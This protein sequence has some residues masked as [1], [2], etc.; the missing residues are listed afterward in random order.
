MN[1]S[2]GIDDLWIIAIAIMVCSACALL[3]V[4]LVLRKLSMIGDAI[5]H[6]VLFG[7]VVAFLLTSSRGSAVILIGATAVGILTTLLINFLSKQ[8]KVQEDA[9]IGVVFTWLFALGVILISYYAGQ[10]DLDQDCVLY[11]EIAFAPLNRLIIGA[12]DIGPKAFWTMAI[13]T[14]INLLFVV[15]GYRQLKTISFDP[16]LATSLGVSITLW[17]YLLMTF[18]SLTA[19]AAFDSVGA[20]L[21]VAMLVI[22]ANAAY[23]IATSIRGMIALALTFGI[24]SAIFGYFLAAYFDASISASIVIV[25]GGILGLVVAYT[26]RPILKNKIA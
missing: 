24:I 21:S 23:L 13:I 18:V 11:G 14:L 17:H 19:V 25:A 4:F 20:I 15:F 12:T 6:S 10:V 16:I 3:G 22:P 5:S 26:V 9:S 2:L 7:I 1:L 8:G